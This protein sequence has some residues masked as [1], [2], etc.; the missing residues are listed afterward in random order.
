MAIGWLWRAR[1][2]AV[3]GDGG[4]ANRG[5]SSSIGDGPSLSA[6]DSCL[7]RFG[8]APICRPG[9]IEHR[10]QLKAGEEFMI[11]RKSRA[12][13]AVYRHR[14]PHRQP[15]LVGGLF[16][17]GHP[18]A[19]RQSAAH[20]PARLLAL[21]QRPLR[22]SQGDREDNR[23]FRN[24]LP[25]AMW[26]AIVILLIGIVL[27]ARSSTTRALS[28]DAGRRAEAPDR[29]ARTLLCVV[30]RSFLADRPA[31]WRG[32]RCSRAAMSS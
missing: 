4:D 13:G 21:Y 2:A 5:L 23:S 31:W 22:A 15:S 30:A 17:P 19:R 11:S 12:D 32:S 20:E 26:A 14:R 25:L 27:V 18:E 8:L 16:Q 10:S 28:G 1:A 9:A 24:T 3:H 7:V 6:S 29:Q